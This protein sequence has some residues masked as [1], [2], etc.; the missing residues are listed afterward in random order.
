MVRP[1]QDEDDDAGKF[2]DT[3]IGRNWA[4]GPP[5]DSLQSASEH[6]LDIRHKQRHRLPA[7]AQTGLC[8][9]TSVCVWTVIHLSEGISLQFVVLLVVVL[10]SGWGASHRWNYRPVSF[11]QSLSLWCGYSRKCGEG[12]ASSFHIA[13]IPVASQLKW[14]LSIMHVHTHMEAHTNTHLSLEA[15]RSPVEHIGL[16]TGPSG[17]PGEAEWAIYSAPVLNVHILKCDYVYELTLGYLSIFSFICDSLRDLVISG[18]S[19]NNFLR[20]EGQRERDR[21]TMKWVEK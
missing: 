13:A 12:A 16:E 18:A 1:S 8:A 4:E 9:A 5:S 6:Q 15:W 17:P 10:L 19:S 20:N 14:T 21:V 7:E 11:F 2:N 3:Y